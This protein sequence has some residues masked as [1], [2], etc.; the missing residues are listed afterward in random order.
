MLI[1][2]GQTALNKDVRIILNYKDQWRSVASPYKT[3]GFSGEI[4]T[5]KKKSQENYIGI[6]LQVYSDK[7][8]DSDMGTYMGSLNISGILKIDDNNKLGLGLMGGY[9]QHS[10]NYSN[11]QWESQYNGSAYVSGA[12]SGEPQN[13]TSYTY[14]DIGAGIAWSYGKDQMYISANNGIHAVVG[15]SAFHFGLPSYSFYTQT[16]EKLNTKINA[17]ATIEFGIKNTNLLIAPNILYT[18]QGTQNELIAGSK[19]KYVLQ[20]GSKYTLIKKSSAIS[21][22]IDYRIEDALITSFMFEYSNYSIGISYDVNMSKL[23]LASNYRG[24]LELALRFVTPNPFNNKTKAR[25]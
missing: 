14:P 20:E 18:K 4:N 8:G 10:V 11:L 5:R 23:K 21:L 6:G 19:F 9:G 25:I 16:N 24:G 3:F 22:G 13:S 2:P 12:S 1:N 17:H 15:I 7:A